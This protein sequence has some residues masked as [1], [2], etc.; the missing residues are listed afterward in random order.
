MV[1]AL[2]DAER[3]RFRHLVREPHAARAQDAALVV[4]HDARRQ[5]VVLGRAHLGLVRHRRLAVEAVVVVLQRAL[6][7]LVADAAVDRVVEQRQLEHRLPVLAHELRVG[8]HAQALGRG[9]VARDLDPAAPLDLHDA[10]AAAAGDRER[11]VVAEVRKVDAA[12]ERRREHG[13][14]VLGR[15]RAPV[16]EDLRHSRFPSWRERL[17]SIQ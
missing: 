9:H 14:P 12:L 6:A 13:L 1:A 4:E 3:M 16:Y 10:H 17:C 2:H 7:G 8:Q 5:R 11:R 15:D